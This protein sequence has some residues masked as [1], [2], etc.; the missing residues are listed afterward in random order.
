MLPS[1]PVRSY[2]TEDSDILALERALNWKA[3]PPLAWNSITGSLAIHLIAL[4]LCLSI[5]H[6]PSSQAPAP[7]ASS[8]AAVQSF[9]PLV[10]PAPP[11]ISK[12]VLGA[13]GR[14]DSPPIEVPDITES[15]VT[16]DLNSIKLY[17]APD[18]GNQLPGIV[19]AHHGM[20]ALL[21]KE[22][23]GMARYLIE[24][25]EWKAHPVLEDISRRLRFRMDPPGKWPVFREAA[26]RSGID[27]HQY[28]GCA[29]FDVAFGRC[30][31]AAIQDFRPD[32]TGSVESAR[33]AFAADQPCGI[34][35]L[36]VRLATKSAPEP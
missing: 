14:F 31:K 19:E 18:L 13:A 25:P 4:A 33:L 22:D 9:V 3:A 28:I 21:D 10:F 24:P 34:K 8:Q 20:L 32:A 5:L 6:G 1:M 2:S 29:V 23:L 11:V 27:L 16:V 17:F 15:K 36:E 26:A 7:A 35:V 12:V 30:L